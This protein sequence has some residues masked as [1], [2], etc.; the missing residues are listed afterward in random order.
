MYFKN[1]DS[2]FRRLTSWYNGFPTLY[3]E[4]SIEDEDEMFIF[5]KKFLVDVNKWIYTSPKTRKSIVN[6]YLQRGRFKFDVNV[7]KCIINRPNKLGPHTIEVHTKYRD[8]ISI[9]KRNAESNF[10]PGVWTLEE[11]KESGGNSVKIVFKTF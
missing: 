4:F 7:C 1:N 8:F 3:T 10:F 5:F 6:L 9:L 11:F 2:C